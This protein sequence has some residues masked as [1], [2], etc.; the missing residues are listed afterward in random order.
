MPVS[1]AF[2]ESNRRETERLRALVGRLDAAALAV[3]L[4][5]GWSVAGALA[6]LGFW[7]RHRLCLMQR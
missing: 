3:R 2:A 6:H 5:N 7:D 1:S 4:P